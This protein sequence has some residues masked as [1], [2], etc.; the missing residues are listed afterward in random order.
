[1]KK[2]ILSIIILLNLSLLAQNNNW[3]FPPNNLNV[4]LG[5]FTSLPAPGGVTP[6]FGIDNYSGAPMLGVNN[7]MQDNNGDLLFFID[8]GNIY[9]AE[10][11]YIAEIGYS[12]IETVIIPVPEN[13]EQYYIVT[14]MTPNSNTNFPHYR[15]LDLSAPNLITERRGSLIDPVT[16]DNDPFS[17]SSV[18]LSLNVT[19]AW[20]NIEN[21]NVF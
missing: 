11:Y 6:F 17:S 4:S 2:I 10:G 9:D 7:S 5:Q 14:S 15:I 3:N 13:C 12:Y 21:K 18:D 19:P 1:M 8:R 16:G 20:T